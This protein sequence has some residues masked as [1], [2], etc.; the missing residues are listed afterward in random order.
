[1]VKLD[2]WINW[3]PSTEFLSSSEGLESS[4]G[5]RYVDS[6]H[7]RTG[8]V[9]Q[10]IDTEFGQVLVGDAPFDLDE[11]ISPPTVPKLEAARKY[12]SQDCMR[13][14]YVVYPSLSEAEPHTAVPDKP[15]V[16][17]VESDYSPGPEV[18]MQNKKQKL[19]TGNEKTERRAPC[20]SKKQKKLHCAVEKRYRNNLNSKIAALQQTVPSLREP[21]KGEQGGE[22]AKE[23]EGDSLYKHRKAVIITQAIEYIS[24]LE[25][26][27]QRLSSEAVVLKAQLIAFKKQL[28][29][30]VGKTASSRTLIAEMLGTIQDGDSKYL[31]SMMKEY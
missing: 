28:A 20:S 5:S 16:E 13:R 12:Q 8:F 9:E 10:S 29:I 30:M 22:D 3:N 17:E 6:E 1:M 7:R 2:D 4:S 24:H 26:S 25:G 18:R 23:S 31:Y 15:I 14:S 21:R 11:Y 27:T 19:S